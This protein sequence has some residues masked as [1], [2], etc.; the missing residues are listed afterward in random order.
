MVQEMIQSGQPIKEA[1]ASF[2]LRRSSWYRHRSGNSLSPEAKTTFYKGEGTTILTRE[3]VEA[4]VNFVVEEMKVL[5]GQH[6]FWGYRRVH[7][8][9][10]HRKGYLLGKKRVRSLMKANGLLVERKRFKPERKLRAK[11]QAD[12]P[13]QF[14]GTD[15]T[16]FLIPSLGW[17]NLT[18]VIDWFTKQILGYALG[19]RGNTV[20][21][22]AALDQAV[23]TAFPEGSSLGKGVQLISDNGSQPTS[24]KY[25]AACKQLGIQQIFTTYDNPKGNADTERVIRTIKEEAIWP[26]EFEAFEEAR[27]RIYWA[28]KF[29]NEEYCHSA[30]NYLSPMEF[31]KAQ[32]E[33]QKLK[34]QGAQMNLEGTGMAV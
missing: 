28:I 3:G 5:V 16:K 1:C 14:W 9:L 27:E 23:Q 31:L 24:R 32:V 6:P 18:V 17:V 30:L 19:L 22:L 10:K 33:K 7:A 2:G 11:P 8:Y 4:G 34:E 12:K 20:L 25:M 21:W 29:Y 15:M 13:N 26:Y